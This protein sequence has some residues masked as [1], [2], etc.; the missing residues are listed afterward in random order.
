MGRV[1]TSDLYLCS[2]KGWAYRELLVS[3]P[4]YRN[5]RHVDISVGFCIDATSIQPDL[6]SA[7][8]MPAW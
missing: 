5:L 8:A 2:V 3:G 6:E 7:G 4:L 1:H